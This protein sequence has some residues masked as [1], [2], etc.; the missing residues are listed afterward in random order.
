VLRR[1][2]G[3]GFPERVRRHGYP[4]PRVLKIR[5]NALVLERIDGPT[6]QRDAATRPWRAW[7]HM[8]LLADLHQ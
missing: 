1:S 7:S 8:R 3:V 5:D 6:M 2:R 4:V